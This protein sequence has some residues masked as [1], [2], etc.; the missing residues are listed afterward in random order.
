MGRLIL[1]YER[2]RK[3]GGGPAEEVLGWSNDTVGGGRLSEKLSL[4]MGWSKR[5]S[6][7]GGDGD[8][9]GVASSLEAGGW[10]VAALKRD[11]RSGAAESLLL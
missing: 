1:L 2:G 7:G 5:S 6:V 9:D 11:S 10:G 4:K 8:G 3:T